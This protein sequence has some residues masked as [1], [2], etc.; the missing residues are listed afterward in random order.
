MLYFVTLFVASGATCYHKRNTADLFAPVAFKAPPTLAD[1]IL[2]VNANTDRVQRLHTDSASISVAN[3]PGLRTTLSLE[4]P[5]RLRLRAKSI[6][7]A[8]LDLGSNDQMFWF[9]TKR[10]SE[11]VIYFASHQEYASSP[12]RGL[13]PVDPHWLVEAIGL[14]RLDPGGFHEEPFTRSDGHVEVRSQLASPNGPRTRVLVIDERYGWILEQHLFDSAGQLLATARTSGH[15]YDQAAQASL[16]HR[17]EVEM[18]AAGLSLRIDVTEFVVNQLYGDPLEL[19]TM[20]PFE[21]YTPV[22]IAAPRFTAREEPRRRRRSLAPHPSPPSRSALHPTY[23]GHS[24]L[25]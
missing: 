21:G 14:V 13:L 9:W 25:R 20:P 12:A 10:L 18:P 8:E 1:V 16:P 19:W 4:R 17:I 7:G 22:N 3:M 15:R 23:R 11:P 6:G 5:N 2:A 24:A